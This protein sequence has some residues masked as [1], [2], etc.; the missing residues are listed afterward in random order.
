L[1]GC[2]CARSAS[3][4]YSPQI[5]RPRK[6]SSQA[7]N[8]TTAQ[9]P[10]PIQPNGHSQ[11]DRH[12]LSETRPEG[13][14]QIDPIG[15][16]PLNS[17]TACLISLPAPRGECIPGISGTSVRGRRGRKTNACRI[18]PVTARAR[19]PTAVIG[20][21]TTVQSCIGRSGQPCAFTKAY[22]PTNQINTGVRLVPPAATCQECGSE[23]AMSL[24]SAT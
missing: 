11:R 16:S 9:H 15:R 8:A 1:S 23:R 13:L 18:S 5:G 10:R 12:R 2:R 14:F 24:S 17:L 20:D 4:R 22:R 19:R 6:Q 21:A 3:H 7:V